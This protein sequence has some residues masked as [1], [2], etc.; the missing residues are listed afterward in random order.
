ML[1]NCSVFRDSL[2]VWQTAVDLVAE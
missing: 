1:N 2:S